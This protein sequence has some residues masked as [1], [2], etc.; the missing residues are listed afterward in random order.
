MAVNQAERAYLA[1]PILIGQA[2]KGKTIAYKALGDA[3]GIHHRTVRYVLG[4]IQDYCLEEKLPP[5]TILIVNQSGKPGGGFIAW[6]VDNYDEGF[7]KVVEY[8]WDLI[9]NPFSYASD[10]ERYDQLI[11]TLIQKPEEAEDVYVKVKTR[12]IAQ[13][14]FRDAL[15]KTYKNKCAFTK[16]S[17]VSGW[18]AAHIIPWYK[19]SKSDRTDMRNGLLLTSFHHS[20]FDQAMITITDDYRIVFYDPD[21]DEGPYSEYD[22]LLTV[23]LHLKKMMLPKNKDH[24][25]LAQYILRHYE[26]HEWSEYLPNRVRAGFTPALPTPP[27]IP[28]SRDR[29]VHRRIH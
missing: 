18:Q 3:I 15:I 12:G 22:K 26:I 7:N 28:A 20:L 16:L 11:T 27:G 9:D 1:W 5:L 14:M 29:A 19:S 23:N 2:K 21:M 25:P 6:D 24:W 17:F 10:G 8:N 4:L 13:S